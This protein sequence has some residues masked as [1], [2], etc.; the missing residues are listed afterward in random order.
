MLKVFSTCIKAHMGMS[1]H[2]LPHAFRTPRAFTN[3][4]TDIKNSLVSVC[5]KL[6][7]NTLGLN[8][9]QVEIKGLDSKGVWTLP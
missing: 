8:V 2:G 4:L 1:G 9:P 6:E 7:L 3:R 5:L